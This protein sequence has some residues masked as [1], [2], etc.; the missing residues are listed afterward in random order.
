MKRLL[1]TALLVVGLMNWNTDSIF[2]EEEIDAIG[3]QII[4]Q[5]ANPNILVN[6]EEKL[7]DS[8]TGAAPISYKGTT[9]LP[10]KNLVEL[11]GGSLEYSKLAQRYQ[12]QLDGKTVQLRADSKQ[13][14]VDGQ[15]RMLSIAPVNIRGTLLVPLRVLSEHLDV[16]MKW[17]KV[18]QRA[19][20]YHGG[21]GERWYEDNYTSKVSNKYGRYSDQSIGYKVNYPLSWGDPLVIQKNNATIETIFYESPFVKISSYSDHMLSSYSENEGLKLEET[22]E[23]Y[24]DRHGFLDGEI[25]EK[26]TFVDKAYDIFIDDGENS[27]IYLVIFKEDEVGVFCIKLN[28]NMTSEDYKATKE[29]GN[30]LN[31]TFEADSAVG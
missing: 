26:R 4:L 10:V 5:V 9:F 6:G 11:L 28:Q 8:A 22:Y 17:D 23:Q 18:Q 15:V 21:M 13:A 19:V 7:L 3:T 31:N 25:K 2:A 20:L 27:Y 14:T 29:W 16:K 12:I 1:I 24:L 30:L